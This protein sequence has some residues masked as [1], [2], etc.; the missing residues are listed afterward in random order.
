MGLRL[1]YDFPNKAAPHWR[2]GAHFRAAQSSTALLV[3]AR[4]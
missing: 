4:R 1:K 2:K 3:L